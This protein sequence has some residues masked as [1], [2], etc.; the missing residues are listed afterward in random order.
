[1]ILFRGEW[2]AARRGF[3]TQKERRIA[4]NAP[5]YVLVLLP[6]AKQS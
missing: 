5:S 2:S 6:S 4:A 3:L 1:M